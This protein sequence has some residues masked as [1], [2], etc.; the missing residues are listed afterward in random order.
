MKT[1]ELFQGQELEIAELIQQRRLQLLVHSCIYYQY[2]QN[3]ISDRQWD[4]WAKELVELQQQYPNISQSVDW[5]DDFQD[6]DGSTGVF[7]P[8]KDPWVQKKAMQL[9]H[10]KKPQLKVAKSQQNKKKKLF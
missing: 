1:Y 10:Y 7:L 9:L 5:Y 2:N 3:L 6:W 8:L 4:K